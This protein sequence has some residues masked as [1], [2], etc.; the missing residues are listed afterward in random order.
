M[1]HDTKLMIS[2]KLACMML[3]Y[4]NHRPLVGRTFQFGPNFIEFFD[5]PDYQDFR[6]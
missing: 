5:Y 4:E 6:N 2:I 1:Y 3:N